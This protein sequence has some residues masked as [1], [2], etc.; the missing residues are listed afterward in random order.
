MRLR[1]YVS[2]SYYTLDP[3]GS[4]AAHGGVAQAMFAPLFVMQ[5]RPDVAMSCDGRTRIGRNRQRASRR[6]EAYLKF[7]TFGTDGAIEAQDHTTYVPFDFDEAH[8]NLG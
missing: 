6:I 4:V 7:S 8:P 1:H 2:F 3:L 5:V